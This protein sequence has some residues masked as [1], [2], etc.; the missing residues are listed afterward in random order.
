MSMRTIIAVGFSATII[1]LVSVFT[2]SSR[3]MVSNSHYQPSKDGVVLSV[4]ALQASERILMV[5]QTAWREEKSARLYQFEGGE[6]VRIGVKQLNPSSLS[7]DKSAPMLTGRLSRDEVFGLDAYLLFLRRGFPGGGHAID[8]VV[9]GYYRDGAKI[10]EERFQDATGICHFIRW[11]NG[12]VSRTEEESIGDFPSEVLREII[13]P[14]VIEDR[15]KEPNKAPEPTTMAV[16]P[17]AAQ[18]SRQP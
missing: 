7:A 4:Q 6:S 10:G 2:R 9:V 15:L 8:C 5:V 11:Q 14:R 13:P 3:T 17:P 18:E 16:T 1:V 12:G